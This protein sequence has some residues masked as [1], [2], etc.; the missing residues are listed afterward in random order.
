MPNYN[1]VVNTTFQP[2]TYQ[3]L[4]AP[5]D[6]A[7]M[8]HEKL[9]EEYDKLSSQADVL[10]AMGQNDRDKNSDVYNQYK[11]Y[12]DDLRKAAEELNRVGLNTESRQ[13][14]TDMRRRYNTDIVPI[15]NAWRKREEEAD[16][17][18]KAQLQ[19]PELRFTRDAANT[20]LGEYIK[21]PEGG[22]GVVNLNNITA[23]ASD[24]FKNLAKQI[25]GNKKNAI[26]KYNDLLITSYGVD[27]NL[28]RDWQNNPNAS[29]TLTSVLHEVL[30]A[31]GL[32]TEDF[33]NTPNGSRILAE[34][35]AAAK[36]GAWSAV[37]E[38]KTQILDNFE[39]RENYKYN[40]NNPNP[41]DDGAMPS[42]T[43]NLNFNDPK[44]AGNEM[45]HSMA[46][47]TGEFMKRNIKSP[48]VQKFMKKWEKRGGLDAAI[49]DWETNGI[50][51]KE[52]KDAGIYYEL[53]NYIRNNV[54]RNEY[55]I[56]VWRSEYS[57]KAD[58]KASTVESTN[59]HGMGYYPSM[60]VNPKPHELSKNWGN[61]DKSVSNGYKV[62]AVELHDNPEKLKN[63]LELKLSGL[64]R[65]GSFRLYSINQIKGN[66]DYEY[67]KQVKKDELPHI[68]NDSSKGIDYSRFKRLLLSNGDYMLRWIDDKGNTQERVLKRSDL[69][70]Q[71]VRDWEDINQEQYK[72]AFRMYSKDLISKEEFDS[73]I[74]HFGKVGVANAYLDTQEVDVPDYKVK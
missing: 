33:L 19:H 14:L 55:A 46:T 10:E 29:S 45:K 30:A 59:R 28:I 12:S 50:D 41:L 52:L 40:L 60:D 32:T 67:G 71:A 47:A 7:E 61:F 35:T 1:L 62:K 49:K 31:N 53:G 25:R 5:L 16:M 3:E 37:G 51:G 36:R 34:A 72:R 26:D 15:Q 43:I 73:L 11:S 13:A 27:P 4:A 21:N 58:A 69:G 6:R 54:T 57:K 18:I 20:S 39:A 48:K 44:S 38:D 22:F 56:N 74:K 70:D 64:G 8:Y 65:D 66:G 17:Q 24:A 23:M 63:Y 9:A 2:F 68:S 42:E